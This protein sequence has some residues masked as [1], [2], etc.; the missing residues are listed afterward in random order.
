MED[1]SFKSI[2]IEGISFVFG[3]FLLALSYN[4][5]LLPNGLAIGGMSGLAIVVES[6]FGFS[7]ELFIYIANISCL[8]ISFI[9]L[10]WIKTKNTIVGSILYPLMITLTLPIANYF[11]PYFIFEE[12]LVIALCAALMHGFSNGLI[13]KCGF[14][15]GGS[16]V[17]MQIIHKYFKIPE[18]K[19]L[20]IVNGFVIMACVYTFGLEKGIYALIIVLTSS[21]VIDRIMYGISD[22]KT[23]YIY[24]KNGR[25]IK[26]LILNEFESGFTILPTKG[27]YSHE[28]GYLIMV[29]ISNKDYYNFKNR[30]LDID[31]QAFIVI[32]SC[33]EVKGGVKRSNLPFI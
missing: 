6:L 22:S 20:C 13:Y 10:D 27:G 18:A 1:K 19:S 33:F 12:P 25:K 17:L 2:I 28:F 3:V 32:Q 31:P 9:F 4:L 21:L 8:I 14:T 30:I 15:T 7:S 29:V 23:F 26:K 5:L 24:T 16:D 11:K